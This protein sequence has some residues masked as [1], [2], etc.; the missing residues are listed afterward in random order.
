MLHVNAQTYAGGSIRASVVDEDTAKPL[1]DFTED[2]SATFKG[3]STCAPLRWR[4][5]D[6]LA[7]L[8]KRYV[9]LA[10]HLKNAKLFSFWVE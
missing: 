7:E 8:K 1:T 6:S 3:D 4:H 10:F 5:R 2:D 9:R